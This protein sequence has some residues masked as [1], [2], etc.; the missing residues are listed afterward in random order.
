MHGIGCES[1]LTIPRTREKVG[2][3]LHLPD[4]MI[5]PRSDKPGQYGVDRFYLTLMVG[6]K[7]RR[8]RLNTNAG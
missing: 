6:E 1:N 3:T 5:L 7:V 8:N 2:L 4:T